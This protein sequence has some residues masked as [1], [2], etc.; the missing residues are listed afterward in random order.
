MSA[1]IFN[2]G[3]YHSFVVGDNGNL[4]ERYGNPPVLLNENVGTY[5]GILKPG[6]EVSVGR[7]VYDP[8]NPFYPAYFVTGLARNGLDSV[9]FVWTGNEWR[10]YGG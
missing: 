1:S 10:V 8:D 2:Q 7:I 6:S 3:A 4:I 9:T 5:A